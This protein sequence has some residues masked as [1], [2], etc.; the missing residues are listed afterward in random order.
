MNQNSIKNKKIK[1]VLGYSLYFLNETGA[2][3]IWGLLGKYLAFHP[4]KRLRITRLLIG[5]ILWTTAIYFML[6]LFVGHIEFKVFRYLIM[7]IISCGITIGFEWIKDELREHY[8][9]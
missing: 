6:I 9:I 4:A 7:L 2:Y 1:G 5:A 3:V 8:E